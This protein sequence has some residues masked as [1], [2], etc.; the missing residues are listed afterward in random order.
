MYTLQGGLHLLATASTFEL[1]PTHQY[2]H[3]PLETM[4]VGILVPCL[5]S[6]ISDLKLANYLDGP[7][8]HA[9][10]KSE[11]A[12]QTG[13]LPPLLPFRCM[14]KAMPSQK[15]CATVA[16]VYRMRVDGHIYIKYISYSRDDFIPEQFSGTDM[17]R[18]SYIAGMPSAPGR[19]SFL[20]G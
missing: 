9:L 13:K 1:P 14:L 11:E 8:Q 19:S 15:V 16:L 5:V 3:M 6:M 12:L 10:I 20:R 18:L 2:I 4:N 7:R 17:K